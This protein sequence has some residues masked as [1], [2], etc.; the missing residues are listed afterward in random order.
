[1]KLH[2]GRRHAGAGQA[3]VEFT[4]AVGLF[5]L[6]AT[7][8]VDGA[9][10][11]NGYVTLNYAVQEGGRVAAL[12]APATTDTEDVCARVSERSLL[13]TI[14]CDEPVVIGADGAIKSFAERTTG[15]RVEVTGR[16]RFV[17]VVVAMFGGRSP[18]TIGSTAVYTVE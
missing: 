13:I 7:G 6:T 2:I 12:P 15:D 1:M 9:R 8:L 11:V 3:L 10:A 14:S 4:L 5:L 17:P 16:Y 18:I